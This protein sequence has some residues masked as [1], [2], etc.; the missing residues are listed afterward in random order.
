MFLGGAPAGASALLAVLRRHA[1]RGVRTSLTIALLERT[2]GQGCGD[3]PVLQLEIMNGPHP[4]QPV[5]RR[6]AGASL[7]YGSPDCEG[8]LL[9]ERLF[10]QLETDQG[11]GVRGRRVR[12]SSAKHG[13]PCIPCSRL[14][15]PQGG[16]YP[17][18]G[19]SPQ[20]GD[21]PR[22]LA[23]LFRR[24]GRWGRSQR[25]SCRKDP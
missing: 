18:N 16:F 19:R 8:A 22:G 11:S 1:R 9:R 7:G 14:L 4:L 2:K 20:C 10:H 17:A 21:Y 5:V 24:L 23:K 6:P 12:L 25:L 3:A 15:G 13:R